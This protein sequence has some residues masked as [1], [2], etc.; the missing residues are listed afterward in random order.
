MS[1]RQLWNIWD[2]FW[3]TP[4][5]PLPL[6][7]YRIAFGFLCLITALL[8]AP[9]L[10]VWFGPNAIVSRDAIQSFQMTPRFSLLFLLPNENSSVVALYAL[11]IISS[12][13]L[14]IGLK[15]RLS[16]FVLFVCLLSFHHRNNLI[17]HSGDTLMRLISLI[18]IFSPAGEILSVDRF[19]RKR[20]PGGSPADSEIKCSPWAQR[21]MQVQL[22]AL[23]CQ[24]FCGKMEGTTWLTGT[25]IYFCARLEEFS[26]FPVPYLF[27]HMWTI[28]LLTWGTLAIEFSLF[29]LV[30]IR[31]FRY[32]VLLAGILLHLGIEWSMNIPVFEYLMIASYLTF[33]EPE[34]LK[35][36]LAFL[37]KRFAR[38]KALWPE[39]VEAEVGQ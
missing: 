17:F 7:L 14:M 39:R 9:D 37:G 2:E 26:R 30:W 19:L 12:L 29:T 38:F 35:R 25:A 4:T 23:Y 5:S 34:D 13:C 10:F 33:V 1:L 21:L 6:C 11:L 3:F 22:A 18:M 15:T 27:D 36:A 16:A 20:R 31:E 8:L 24:S 32:F 28:K